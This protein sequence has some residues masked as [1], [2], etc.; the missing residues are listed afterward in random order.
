MTLVIF[1]PSGNGGFGYDVT[2]NTCSDL[3]GHKNA[4][5]FNL[6]QTLIGLPIPLITLLVCYL[7]IYIHLRNHFRQQKHNLPTISSCPSSESVNTIEIEDP[8]ERRRT[9]ISKQQIMI[10]KNLFFIVCAFFACFVPFLILNS[11]PALA[12]QVDYLLPLANSAT[13]FFIYAFNHPEFKIVFGHMIRC[14]YS[15]IPEPSK[16]LQHFISQR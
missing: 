3:D 2:D 7:W 14:T 11:I 6:A 10:T 13:N 12:N 15:K 5:I 1:L 8:M 16:L 4:D 9:Q